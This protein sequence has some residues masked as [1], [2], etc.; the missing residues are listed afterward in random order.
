MTSILKT[1]S[2]SLLSL[3][4]PPL[5]AFLFLFHLFFLFF[6]FLQSLVFHHIHHVLTSPSYQPFPS[7]YLF[8]CLHAIHI[9]SD[10]FH[11]Y[12][13]FPSLLPSHAH[14]FLT[15]LSFF[16]SISSFSLFRSCNFFLFKVRNCF[17]YFI[18]LQS[19]SLHASYLPF[20]SFSSRCLIFYFLLANSFPLNCLSQSTA[21]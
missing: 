2:G 4:P 21:S 20:L 3:L 10:F 18:I 8:Q 5:H 13:N 16:L 6:L 14:Y 15:T 9:L 1:S 12:L 11:L 7:I 17:S 19:H